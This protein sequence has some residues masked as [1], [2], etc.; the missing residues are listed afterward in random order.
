MHFDPA[1]AAQQSFGRS[2]EADELG[3]DVCSAEDA[4]AIFSGSAGEEASCAYDALQA[5]GER[6]PDAPAFQE[7][8]IYI[9]WQQ[10]TEETIPRHFQKGLDLCDRY[11]KRARGRP[12]ED[13][14]LAQIQELRQSFRAGLGLQEDDVLEEF[15]ED[16]FRGGD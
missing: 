13:P 1:V 7:F 15:D 16:R 2:R 11:L 5:L 10:V 4:E 6:H 9:T 14:Q 12:G 8:L 3:E